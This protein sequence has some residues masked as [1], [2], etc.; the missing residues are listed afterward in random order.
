MIHVAILLRR[1]CG[2]VLGGQ[3]T[4]ESRLMRQGREP[5]GVVKAGERVF[6]KQSG[7]PFVGMAEVGWVEEHAGLTPRRVA[8][9]R[10]RYEPAVCG[11]DAYWEGKSAS[12]FA[13][14]MGLER[15]E[16]MAVGPRYAVQ[17]MRAWYALP[18]EVS[19]VREVVLRGGAVRNG[20][21]SLPFASAKMRASRVTLEL[22]GG[23]VVETDFAKGAML[24]SRVFGRLYAEHGV[25]GGDVVRLVRVGERRYVV[26][27]PRKDRAGE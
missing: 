8:G 3:K 14:F 15:V 27:F 12:R 18:E 6:L 23:G 26:S 22:P 7:G 25:R 10:E 19:P 5:Y 21:L 20:Y 1:Y 9:L 4:V 24:R 2:L 16:P 11:D 17:A 13:V